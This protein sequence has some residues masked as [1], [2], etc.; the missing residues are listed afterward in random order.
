MRERPFAERDL[1]ILTCFARHIG[2]SLSKAGAGKSIL[3]GDSG[4][5]HTVGARRSMV[6]TGQR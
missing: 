3:D 1:D 6:A 4:A 2:S 5:V